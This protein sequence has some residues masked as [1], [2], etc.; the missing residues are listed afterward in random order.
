MSKV[1]ILSDFYSTQLISRCLD[2]I[3][4][5]NV[6]EII[7]LEEN[8]KNNSTVWGKLPIRFSIVH[9]IEDCVFKSDVVLILNN[10]G[11][12]RD[13]INYTKLLTAKYNKLLFE[14]QTPDFI[15]EAILKNKSSDFYRKLPP[16]NKLK[17]CTNILLINIGTLSLCTNMEIMLREILT[18]YSA[19]LFQFFSEHTLTILEQMET[20]SII[21]E[22]H[23][24]QCRELR[25]SDADISIITIDVGCDIQ[26]IWEY[27]QYVKEI[28]PD[29]VIV[30]AN[31][32][33]NSIEIRNYVKYHFER[34]IDILS[35]SP[36]YIVDNK[37][38]INIT[39]LNKLNE[40]DYFITDVEI[41][42]AIKQGLLTKLSLPDGVFLH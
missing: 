28:S 18:N 20:Q 8:H 24:A 16:S 33:N 7:L 34:S 12:S 35:F 39:S 31:I 36:F 4:N 25:P 3:S 42:D 21:D 23:I 19:N 40:H 38:I 6:S 11:V 27:S 13:S 5:I 1:F 26:S 41:I 32:V 15:M 22:K 30:T 10:I 14:I 17:D 29:F 9:T 37:H 2:Y